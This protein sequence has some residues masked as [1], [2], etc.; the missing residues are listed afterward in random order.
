[1]F[2]TPLLTL[3]EP[4]WTAPLLDFG[5]IHW[6]C[7]ETAWLTGILA[8]EGMSGSLKESTYCGF[9]AL[10]LASQALV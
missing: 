1:M 8:W 2:A 3:T 7:E 9:A 10:T 4:I 5:F 6:M